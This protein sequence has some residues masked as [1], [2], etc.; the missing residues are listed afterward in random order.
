MHAPSHQ[1]DNG[2][3]MNIF[4]IKSFYSMVQFNYKYSTYQLARMEQELNEIEQCQ[5]IKR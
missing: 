2:A 5:N 4:S 3:L 1:V